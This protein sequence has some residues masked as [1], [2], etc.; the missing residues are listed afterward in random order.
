M[1]YTTLSSVCPLYSV[2]YPPKTS[3]ANLHVSEMWILKA[4]NTHT[5]RC[6]KPLS[7]I[8]LT[9]YFQIETRLSSA[10]QP[11]IKNAPPPIQ[12]KGPS[13]NT[14]RQKLGMGE[15]CKFPTAVGAL[16]INDFLHAEKMPFIEV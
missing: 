6:F 13:P 5:K 9:D 8:M 11:F 15:R 12:K 1:D 2:M 14:Q 4:E 16:A 10:S 7:V 3:R